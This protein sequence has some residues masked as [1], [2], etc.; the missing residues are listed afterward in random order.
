MSQAFPLV[1][2]SAWNDSGGGFTHRLFDGHSDIFSWPFELQLGT[3]LVHDEYAPLFHKKYRWPVFAEPLGAQTPES[4]FDAIIDDELKGNLKD[5]ASSKFAGFDV[6]ADRSAWKSD[7]S[8]R[9]SKQPLS[10]ETIIQTYIECFFAQWKNRK[11]SGRERLYLGH[12]PVI[13]MDLQSILLDF[14]EMKMIHVVRSPYSGIADMRARRPEISAETYARKWAL[15]NER[16]YQFEVQYPQHVKIV[17]F[18]DLLENREATMK[19][20]CKWLGIGFE[21]CLLSPTWNSVPLSHMGPFGGVRE[22]SPEHEKTCAA[23]VSAKDKAII[24]ELT[25]AVRPYF[26]M[27]DAA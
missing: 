11:A 16:A 24:T 1:L 21:P 5:R 6:Q 13:V 4:L 22:I 19:A 17:H 12:C 7:F 15:V 14:P 20:L 26:S 27:G 8:A 10:R 18:A 25:A 9:L 23:S 3:E 2:I